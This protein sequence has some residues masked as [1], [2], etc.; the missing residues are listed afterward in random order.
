[1]KQKR[2][3]RRRGSPD[4]LISVY[5]CD[6]SSIHYNPIPEYHPETEFVRVEKGYLIVQIGDISHIFHAG[7]IF[8][9][10]GNAVHHY[11]Y[12]SEDAQYCSLIFSPEAIT[13]QPNHFFQKSFVQPLVEDRLQLP[14]LLQP[15]HPV[16][17]GV[18]AQ[19]DILPNAHMFAK[20]YQARR[21]SALMNICLLLL[22]YC[23]VISESRPPLDPGNETVRKCMRYIHSRYFQKITLETLAKHCHLHPNYLCALFKAYTGQTI[24]DYLARFRIETAAELLRNEDLPAGKVCALVG[25]GSESV[26]YSKFKAIMGVTPKAYAEQQRK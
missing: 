4:L 5:F 15:G 14:A 10:P 25:F 7:D 19:F 1:M 6:S 13:M 11:S 3:Y 2:S 23:T 22:P 9:I 12:A 26:F 8:V 18:S 20:D 16:Y 21:F 17:E 24:F